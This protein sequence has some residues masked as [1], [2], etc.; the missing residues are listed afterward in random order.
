M[1]RRFPV[2]CSPIRKGTAPCTSRRL[3]HNFRP[4]GSSGRFPQ[5]CKHQSGMSTIQARPDVRTHPSQCPALARSGHRGRFLPTASDASDF[6]LF[7]LI[8]ASRLLVTIFYARRAVI[9]HAIIHV[10]SADASSHLGPEMPSV[11]RLRRVS[12][13]RWL[14]CSRISTNIPLSAFHLG[15][16]GYMTVASVLS[17]KPRLTTQRDSERQLRMGT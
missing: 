9:C 6:G 2:S 4:R 10:Q 17:R 16:V 15:D 1:G 8:D 11:F 12:S 13:I 7:W 3:T 5:D 14:Y